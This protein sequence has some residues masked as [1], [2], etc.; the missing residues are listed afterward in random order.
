MTDFMFNRL[1]F[2]AFCVFSLSACQSVTNSE[3]HGKCDQIA[4][5][6]IHFSRFDETVQQL[7]HATGC[8]VETDL[9][10]TGSVRPNAVKGTLSIREAVRTAIAGTDLRITHD[11]ANVIRIEKMNH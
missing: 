10:Q 8:F 6:D 1:T 3:F 4:N 2:I 9:G 7:V 11:D 5:Y